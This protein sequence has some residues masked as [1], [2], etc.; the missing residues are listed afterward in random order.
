MRPII[1]AIVVAFSA[2]A[3][4]LAAQTETESKRPEIDADALPEFIRPFP[5]VA[6]PVGASAA[7]KAAAQ[8][9]ANAL[10]V[11]LILKQ[12]VNPVC[13]I[14]LEVIHWTPNPGHG[15]YI[16][17]NQSGGSLISASDEEQLEAAVD[18]FIASIRTIDGNPHVPMG[19]LTNYR[20]A[21]AI[22]D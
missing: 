5:I 20:I 11:K 16:I 13:C 18:R 8:R 2:G 12:N 7:H 22:E 10:G 1:A 9:I 15:G 17:N 4:A 6:H 21:A 3:I 19:I 14:W